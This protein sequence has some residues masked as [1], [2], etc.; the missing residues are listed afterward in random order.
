VVQVWGITIGGAI[1][2]TEVAKRLPEQVVAFLPHGEAGALQYAI[3]PLVKTLPEPL[4]TEVRKAF[5]DS[6]VYVWCAAAGLSGLGLLA[7][8]PMELL[9]LHT[10]VDK[11]WTYQAPRPV[12]P[13]DLEKNVAR[14][15]ESTA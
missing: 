14:P 11:R 1:L 10:E 9:P 13:K 4:Q 12:S 2:Q 5:G 7:S 8:L 3:I 6:L 15:S